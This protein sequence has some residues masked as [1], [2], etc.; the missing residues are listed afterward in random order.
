MPNAASSS[1]QRGPV[2]QTQ[3]Q[4]QV[5]SACVERAPHMCVCVYGARDESAAINLQ[6]VLGEI[7]LRK[8]TRHRQS[9]LNEARTATAISGL[10]KR[11]RL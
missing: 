11:T 4:Q 3:H 8:A 2:D 6:T 10:Y 7:A 1:R 5:S 9:Q